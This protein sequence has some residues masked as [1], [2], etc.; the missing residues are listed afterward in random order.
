M[1]I[2][3][4]LKNKSFEESSYFVRFLW[5]SSIINTSN[6]KNGQKRTPL[7]IAVLD[8]IKLTTLTLKIT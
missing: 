7:F 6:P 2:Q 5:C 3:S 1:I 4:Q 8:K